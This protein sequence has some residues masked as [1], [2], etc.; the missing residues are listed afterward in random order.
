MSDNSRIGRRDILRNAGRFALGAAHHLLDRLLGH[1]RDAERL[2]PFLRESRA[3]LGAARRAADLLEGV[4]AGEAAQ[5]VRAHGPDADEAENLRLARP[6]PLARDSRG[7]RASDGVAPVLVDDGD[8][9]AAPR[10]RQHDVARVAQS[11]HR[12]AHAVVVIVVEANAG[13]RDLLQE[14]GL[15]VPMVVE[16]VRHVE[17]ETR[18]VR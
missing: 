10:L 1:D 8:G 12:V 13:G 3:R 11:A 15:D 9:L 14:D 5:R 16:A 7:G 2:R 17:L 6:H 18:R 4:H